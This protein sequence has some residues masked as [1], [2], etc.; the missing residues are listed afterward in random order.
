MPLSA[1][2]SPSTDAFPLSEAEAC[3]AQRPTHALI[4]VNDVGDGPRDFDADLTIKARHLV[5]FT[6]QIYNVGGEPAVLRY[7]ADFLGLLPAMVRDRIE[8]ATREA[9]R[10]GRPL[11]RDVAAARCDWNERT[12]RCVLNHAP[13]NGRKAEGEN[14]TDFYL[15]FVDGVEVYATPPIALQYLRIRNRIDALFRVPTRGH[16]LF[17]EGEQFR[18]SVIGKTAHEVPEH[19]KLVWRRGEDRAQLDAI[20]PD[21]ARDE[22]AFV[23]SPYGNRRVI[24]SDLARVQESINRERDDEGAVHVQIGRSIVRA[25]IADCLANVP[26]GQWGLWFNPADVADGS[27][28]GYYEVSRRYDEGKDWYEKGQFPGF[29][30][31]RRDRRVGTGVEI[32]PK[33][34]RKCWR[35]RIR[36]RTARFRA[37]R[38]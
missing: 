14:G 10:H 29:C 31:A 11:P 34:S 18:S 26:E 13:R 35:D 12:L 30:L 19:L 24:T 2:P 16:P 17:R 32:L 37:P 8:L 21:L 9:E 33:G 36:E 22:V 38:A 5:P 4:E 1:F 27:R 23:D 15:A 3:I 6:S 28:A 25:F 7:A 20:I